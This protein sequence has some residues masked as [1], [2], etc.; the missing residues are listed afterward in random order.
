MQHPDST[1]IRP[2]ALDLANTE[3]AFARMSDGELQQAYWLF[4][5]ISNPFLV[6]CGPIL[7]SLSLKM[8]LPVRGLIKSTFFGQFCGGESIEECLPRVEGLH[9]DGVGTI[10]DYAS[11]ASNSEDDFDRVV[12]ETKRTI[13]LAAGNP[14]IPFAVFKPS[15][16]A[17][18]DLLEKKDR[19][20]DL[21]LSERE[22]FSRI[23]GRFEILCSYAFEKGVRLLIDAE[24]SWIQASIDQIVRRMM[25]AYNQISPIV[26]NTFQMYRRDRLDYL[27]QCYGDAAAGNYYL[28]VKL[29]RGAYLEKETSRAKRLFY[30]SPLHAS[31]EATDQDF[32]LALRFCVEHRDR[33]ALCAGTHNERSTKILSQLL[34]EY[35]IDKGDKGFYFA[36]LLG[37]SDHLTFNLAGTGHN[38]CKYV[39]YGPLDYLL[40]YLSRRAEE[41]S[42]IKGQAGR[43]LSLIHAEIKRRRL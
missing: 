6:K 8:R 35:S 16:I 30:K 26:Y 7:A 32:N 39:P 18:F 21:S 31:K 36:Q 24:E 29:V 14:G 34:D 27:R 4:K 11:E 25:Q 1:S 13:D 12:A 9:G 20:L 43:E 10:L 33:I 2:S 42:A 40:P 19:H 41:N 28:G 38:V 5:L 17:R 15:G 23:E 3:I 22:E 37:M